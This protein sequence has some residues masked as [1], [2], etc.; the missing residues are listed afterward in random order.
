MI[1]QRDKQMRVVPIRTDPE[2]YK[3]LVDGILVA[4]PAAHP[5]H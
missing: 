1:S 4:V 5:G 3:G 2:H